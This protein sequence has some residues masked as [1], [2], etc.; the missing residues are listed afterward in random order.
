MNT[1]GTPFYGPLSTTSSYYVA[2][3]FASAKGMILSISSKYPRLQMCNAFNATMI[4]DYPEEQEYLIGHIYMR[5]RMIYIKITPKHIEMNS[6]LRF[7]F[8]VTHLFRQQIFSMNDVLEQYLVGFIQNFLFNDQNAKKSQYKHT[9]CDDSKYFASIIK[10]ARK[11]KYNEKKMPKAPG[12]TAVKD[13]KEEI[14]KHKVFYI[15]IK[16]FRE[17]C[18]APNKL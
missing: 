11:F 3:S 5:V 6:K 13:K 12:V 4:S 8:F 14:R 10:W 2:Q 7:A 15:L 17:F 9:K 16:K 1:Y 18:H